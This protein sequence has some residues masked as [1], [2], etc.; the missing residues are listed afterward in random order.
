M[1][2]LSKL[3]SSIHVLDNSDLNVTMR[4]SKKDGIV[5]TFGGEVTTFIDTMTGRVISQEPYVPITIAFTLVK[6][7]ALAALYQARIKKSTILGNVTVTH[8]TKNLATETVTD[9][10][11]QSIDPITN[12]GMDAGYRVTIGGTLEINNELWGDL[13]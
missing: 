4:H 12:D 5:M 6:T 7:S 11:I 10:A 9:C 8:D 13:A 3:L 2:T 1:Q